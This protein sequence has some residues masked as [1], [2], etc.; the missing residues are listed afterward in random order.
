M[1][2]TISSSIQ[3][4]ILHQYSRSITAKMHDQ[5]TAQEQVRSNDRHT[6]VKNI[7]SHT[8]EYKSPF[9]RNV[10]SWYWKEYLNRDVKKIAD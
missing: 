8:E 6:F 9:I 10:I 5:R 4:S 7:R 3:Y 2:L 1:K